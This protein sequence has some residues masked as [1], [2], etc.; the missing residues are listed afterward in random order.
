MTSYA[1]IKHSKT[2]ALD[3]V[4][5]LIKLLRENNPHYPHAENKDDTLT[6]LDK[7]HDIFEPTTQKEHVA[8]V[9]KVAVTKSNAVYNPQLL[10]F[11]I[12]KTK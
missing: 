7:V 8:E 1:D 11:P 10:R 6:A 3:K 9:P 4:K 12:N 5:Y 2:A